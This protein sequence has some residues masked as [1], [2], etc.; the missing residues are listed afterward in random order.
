M[1]IYVCMYVCARARA[2]RKECDYICNVKRVA[3]IKFPIKHIPNAYREVI[4]NEGLEHLISRARRFGA[5]S[6]N[7]SILSMSYIVRAKSVLV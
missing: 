3:K 6:S 2:R 5:L 1:Y 4:R 7:D